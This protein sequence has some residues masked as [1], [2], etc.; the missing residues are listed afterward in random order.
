[1]I[2]RVLLFALFLSNISA[3]ASSTSRLRLVGI[4]YPTLSVSQ[5]FIT[6]QSSKGSRARGTRVK[7][8]MPSGSYTV[9]E[10]YGDISRGSLQ[11]KGYRKMVVEV[12]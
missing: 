5:P 1:M 2:S 4:V 12:K 3:A 11:E 8:N 10:D 6:G 7:T 9:Y